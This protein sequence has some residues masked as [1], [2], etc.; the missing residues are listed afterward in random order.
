MNF[1]IAPLNHPLQGLPHGE[2]FRFFV[3]GG[4]FPG[5]KGMEIQNGNAARK[6]F[7]DPP[8]SGK[9]FASLS[10]GTGRAGLCFCQWQFSESEKAPAPAGFRQ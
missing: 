10:A 9:N 8:S 4:D 2:L 5:G 7:A 6:A 3:A 1:R